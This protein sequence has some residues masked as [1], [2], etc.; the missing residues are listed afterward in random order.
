MKKTTTS[1]ATVNNAAVAIVDNAKKTDKLLNTEQLSS[2]LIENKLMP[3]FVCG[4]YYVGVG[5]GRTNCFSIN[6]RSKWNEYRIYCNDDTFKAVKGAN[7][8]GVKCM[9]L[10]NKTDKV[11]PH[12]IEVD[13]TEGLKK[14]LA[15][16]A[17]NFKSFCIA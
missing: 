16:V 14:V 11:R 4:G 3:R 1:L 10:D 6:T 9:S 17:K 7:I 5:I 2:L 13:S 15:V 8:A 12:T